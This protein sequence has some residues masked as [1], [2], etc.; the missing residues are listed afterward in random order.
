MMTKVWALLLFA[1]ITFSGDAFC[2]DGVPADP[3]G[4]ANPEVLYDILNLAEPS[5]AKKRATLIAKNCLSIVGAHYVLIGEADG[6]AK[7]RVFAKLDDW[8]S[9][10]VVF[11]LDEMLNPDEM[12]EP[13]V[14]AHQ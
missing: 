4:C 7:I 11:T 12:L 5:G 3:L 2:D 13:S 8:A 10:S 9:S 6:L 14:I 1:V